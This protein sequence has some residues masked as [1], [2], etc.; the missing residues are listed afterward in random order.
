MRSKLFLSFLGTLIALEISLKQIKEIS[1]TIFCGFEMIIL[2]DKMTSPLV[3]IQIHFSGNDT[4]ASAKVYEYVISNRRM[5]TNFKII[6][7]ARCFS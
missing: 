3:Y 7:A 5:I 6:Y 2:V 1:K 4:V